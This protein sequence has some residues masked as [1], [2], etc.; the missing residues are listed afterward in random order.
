M[1]KTLIIDNEA[2]IRDTLFKL[3]KRHCPDAVVVGEASGVTTGILAIREFQPDLVFLD[4]NL[5]DGSG[6]DLLHGLEPVNFRV[7]FISAFD[8]K[9]I[10]AFNLS[11][12]EYLAKPISP[13]EL[14]ESIKRVMRSDIKD[15]FLQLEALEENVRK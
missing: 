14:C 2:H 9:T 5:D 15:F 12:L 13:T 1:L 11:G 6:F 8:K 7:I 10:L 3:L 4:I